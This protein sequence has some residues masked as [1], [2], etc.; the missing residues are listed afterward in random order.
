MSPD[1]SVILVRSL[2]NRNSAKLHFFMG[3]QDEIALAISQRVMLTNYGY[4]V[5]LHPRMDGVRSLEMLT[6]YGHTSTL[7]PRID[8]VRSLEMLTNYGY[9]STLHPRRRYLL[10][11]P[12]TAKTLTNVVLKSTTRTIARRGMQGVG[13]YVGGDE[14]GTTGGVKLGQYSGQVQP[15]AEPLCHSEL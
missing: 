11:N 1:D 14:R 13:A 8:R 10:Q 4:T 2:C 15:L 7:H 12:P 9:T 6:N 5:T 3:R